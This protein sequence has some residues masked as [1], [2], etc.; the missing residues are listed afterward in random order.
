M[1]EELKNKK[2]LVIDDFLTFRQAMKKMLISIDAKDIDTADSGESAIKEMEIKSYDIILCDYN[3]GIGKKDGQQVLEEAK[4]RSLIKYS[5]IFIMLTAENTMP[6]VMGAVEYQPDDYL[7][8]PIAKEILR[9]RMEKIIKKKD[10]FEDI[11][12]AIDNK[13]YMSAIALCDER[14]KKNPRNMLEYLRL[15]STICITIGRY[16]DA[17]E[18]FEM[19][20]GMRDIPWARMGVGKV[21][22]FKGAYLKAKEVFQLIIEENKTFM[23]AYD[24]MSKTLHELGSLDEAQRILKRATE[25]SPKAILR[26]QTLGR[27]S[28]EINDYDTAEEA[29]R[30]A[31][32][33]GKH[34]CFKGP[35]E[36]TGLAKTLLKKDASEEALSVLETARQEFKGNR[37]AILQTVVTEG[38]IYKETN[39]EDEAKK[40]I[41]EANKLLTGMSGKIPVEATLDLAKMCFEM[42]D[43]ETGTRLM[44][45]IVKN[46]HDNQ[47]VIDMVQDIFTDATLEDEGQKMISSTRDE[48]IRLNNKGVRLVEDEKYEEAIEYF[49]K[50]ANG[51]PEN[52]IIN[53]NAAHA[54]LIYMEKMGTNDQYIYQALQ[55]L[56]KVKAIDPA[57]EKY[58]KLLNMYEKITT[59]KIHQGA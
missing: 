19:V 44:K 49:K 45:D 48:I 33:I 42:G 28:Q 47:K 18:V 55:Y 35:V 14:V 34:S 26:H 8:K 31:I 22:F 56:E 17:N 24:W 41:E 2:F 43:K 51:L 54:L 40:T 38:I 11:E 3:L 21:H 7:I 20:L 5:T 50:A 39:R 6:M 1:S 15:K 46:N 30:S 27:I 25:I 32:D 29:F 9:S 36:Y 10:D 23:E 57:D 13:E 52:K 37:D 58:Q 12:K 4:H 59:S 53:A 16:D